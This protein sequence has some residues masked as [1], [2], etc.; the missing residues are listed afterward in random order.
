MA[1]LQ[2]WAV[3]NH[4]LLWTMLQK[5]GSVPMGA[6][7]HWVLCKWEGAWHPEGNLGVIKANLDRSSKGALTRICQ[8]SRASPHRESL[9][10][11]HNGSLKGARWPPSSTFLTGALLPW[12]VGIHA[13]HVAVQ[14][15]GA[16]AL[17]RVTNPAFSLAG[18]VLEGVPELE[19]LTQIGWD[20]WP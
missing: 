3:M 11:W 1:I 13:V 17:D 2:S 19:Q 14:V 4:A 8:S 18:R 5:W 9:G 10:S 7:P 15:L 16:P 6:W 20:C 12:G